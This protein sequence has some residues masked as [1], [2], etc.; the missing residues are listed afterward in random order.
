MC[1]GTIYVI[2]KQLT[3]DDNTMQVFL[4]NVRLHPVHNVWYTT[5][6]EKGCLPGMM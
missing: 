6:R 4:Y 2:L 5:Q 3:Y 1:V